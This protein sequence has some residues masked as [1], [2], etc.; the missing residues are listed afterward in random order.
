MATHGKSLANRT[1]RWHLASEG[2]R[3]LL[4][5]AP[6]FQK[7][8]DELRDLAK[9]INVLQAKQA[10]HQSQSQMA[11]AKLRALAKRGDHIRGRIGAA[12]RSRFGFDA[13]ELIQCGFTPRKQVKK[14]QMDEEVEN[15]REGAG[16]A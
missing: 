14:D 16:E 9:E 7:D 2:A 11:T 12:I 13:T 6:Q 5:D 10:Y 1:Q 15:E 3:E 4:A 8:L